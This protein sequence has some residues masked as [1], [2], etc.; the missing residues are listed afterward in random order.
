MTSVGR[1]PA[2]PERWQRIKELLNAALDLE[3]TKR[4]AYLNENCGADTELREEVTELL[5]SYENAGE[6]FLDLPDRQNSVLD[7]FKSF[8]PLVGNLVGPY[9]I[10]EE[11]GQGGMGSVYKAVR[12]DDLFKHEVAVKI[13]RRGMN[14]E[15][16]LRRFRHERQALA[17]LDHPNVARLLDGGLTDEGAPYFVM[18]Y[19][20]GRPIDAYCD[21][22][23]LNTRAR[24]EMFQQVCAGVQAA[25]DRKI[26]HR[27]IKPANILVDAQGRPR[28]LD[29]GIA[30]ILD[31]ELSTQTLDPTAT[32]LRLM[33]PEYASPEQVCGDEIT[34]ASDVYSLGVLLY[35]LLTGHRPYRM[36]RRSP[37]E[38]AQVIMDTEPERPS[39]VVGRT[40][41][42]T[43]GLN[44]AVTL[45]PE[46]VSNVR[47]A[48]P[49]ELR[50]MLT[51]DLDNIILMA[52]RKEPHRRYPCASDLGEDIGRY[53]ERMPV[54]ARKDTL[55]YRVSKQLHR[56]RKL[57]LVAS[58][59]MMV[60]TG[61]VIG[62]NYFRGGLRN[63]FKTVDATPLTSFPGDETQP[64]FSRDGKKVAF[65]WAGEDNDN[66][67]IYIRDVN[68]S[69]LF[70]LTTNTAEDVS[71]VWAPDGS[72]V[73]FLR[74][75]ANQTQVFVSPPTG[76]IHGVIT[77][78][79]PTRFE[80]VG[81][82]LDWSPDG[83]YLVAADKKSPDEPFAIVLVEV[84][85][86]HKIQ[87]TSPPAGMIGD[88]GPSFSP[89]GSSIAFVRAISSGVDDIFVVPVTGAGPARRITTDRRY[90]ISLTWA[91]DGKSI[92]FSTNR[93]GAHTLWRVGLQDGAIERV[94]GIAENVSDPVFSHDG[95]RLAYSQFYIDTNI[96]KMDIASGESKPF[97]ASTQYDSSAQYSPDN[98]RIAFRSSRSGPGEIWI[99]NVGMP[100]GATQLSRFNAG[101][102]G[103]P[104]WSPDGTKIAC[105][106]RPNGPPDIFTLDV[107]TGK[108]TQI[109]KEAAEDVVPSWSRDGDWIYFASNRTGAS[110]VW[111]APAHGGPA[112][113]VT[114][115]GG[116]AAVESPDG[117]YVYYAKGRTV[118]GLWRIPTAGGTEEPVLTR[119][120]AGH[121]GY[122]AICGNSL[123]F[124]DNESPK[125]PYA[126]YRHDLNTLKT[127]R[128]SAIKKPLV[129]GDLGLAIS[130]DCKTA[131]F[132]QRDQ[133]GSDIMIVDLNGKQ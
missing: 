115:G 65:V 11:I 22:Q 109:T 124:L 23:R 80:A 108:P 106:S 61:A 110:Q 77:A 15:F 113:Q 38:I 94:P 7:A 70:R 13:V 48:R 107:S 118:T 93:L 67:D 47:R 75:A 71:P 14:N 104:R 84:A 64:S 39:T 114:T 6:E 29:F 30:K 86:G 45:T 125:S 82:H 8:D 5:S 37:H 17:A 44:P 100:A 31:P 34:S 36:K 27:D 28:L 19:I 76:G 51:G 81:R 83:K 116:F 120:K 62:W 89:D 66:S 123:Y 90:I 12:A 46:S 103:A 132:T 10:L 79:Y 1:Q 21:E 95:R 20:E 35:E 102:T 126:L 101:L 58:L 16:I 72:R 98:Q 74:V 88:S 68:G 69:S 57:V 18:E 40:E 129:I 127:A 128:L 59:A 130:S 3:P 41:V 97:V 105:D 55:F 56:N 32:I 25:H 9:R 24:L 73:A 4:A 92:L 85:T 112:Q 60:G 117:R 96:W 63:D 121:W 99:A 119:L 53:L 111:K 122:W 2:N 50:R 43:R 87:V 133:S 49:E 52:M 91:P 33:T 42:V 78:L 131:L 26:V 54:S